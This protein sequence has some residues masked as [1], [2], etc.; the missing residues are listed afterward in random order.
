M[1]LAV[2]WP[3]RDVQIWQFLPASQ[4]R[5]STLNDGWLSSDL[6]WINVYK[7]RA[8]LNLLGLEVDLSVVEE[9]GSA[10]LI[11]FHTPLNVT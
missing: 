7:F 11:E 10:F 6:V 2:E 8:Y 5:Y 1:L 3:I 4:P 9:E